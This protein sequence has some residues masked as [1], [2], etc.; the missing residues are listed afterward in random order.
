M[1]IFDEDEDGSVMSIGVAHN[2]SDDMPEDEQTFYLD[3]LN[4]L[5]SQLNTGLES[6]AFTGMLL[7]QLAEYEEEE[8]G[9]EF[10]P[11]EELLEALENGKVIQLKK[12]LH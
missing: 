2:L 6:L 9:I 10:E 11:A 5:V 8:G 12:K 3:A 7:R 1:L 4:G